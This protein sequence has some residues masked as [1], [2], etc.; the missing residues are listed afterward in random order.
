MNKLF[1]QL[2]FIS[3]FFISC[4]N[5]IDLNEKW[6]EIPITYGILNPDDTAQY[7][8][9]EKG[10]I[11]SVRSALEIAK[12]PDSLYFNNLE[13]KLIST[14]DSQ[15]YLLNQIDGNLDNHVRDTGVF[16]NTPNYLYKIRTDD[17]DLVPA[18]KYS[19]VAL[20]DNGDT[21][22]SSTISLVNDI[23]IYLPFSTEKPVNLIYISNFNI[24]WEGGDSKGY[25]DLFIKFHI[26]EKDTAGSNSWEKNDYV[27][28]VDT[29]IEQPK[30]RIEGKRFYE[31]LKDNLDENPDIIRKFLGFDIII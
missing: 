11:D 6:K 19:L 28:R 17:I 22:T 18:E 31:F 16:A 2:L 3:A 26:K 10:F 20:K 29:R 30:Y 4:S 14:K 25:F 21:L 13:V 8:R 5:D 15:E 12:I 24:N 23:N 1:I 9:I 27:W 7:I